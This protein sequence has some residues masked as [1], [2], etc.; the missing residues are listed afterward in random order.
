MDDMKGGIGGGVREGRGMG[1]EG[2]G[3][4]QLLR[5][6]DPPGFKSRIEFLEFFLNCVFAQ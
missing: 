2:K 4:L 6:I 1:G 3:L 5:G